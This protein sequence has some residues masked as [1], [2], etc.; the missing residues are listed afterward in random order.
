[1][2]G[3]WADLRTGRLGAR[4]EWDGSVGVAEVVG[5]RSGYEVG[6]HLWDGVSEFEKD[7]SSFGDSQ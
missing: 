3:E 1:L 7:F 5:S 4:D 6:V 2:L